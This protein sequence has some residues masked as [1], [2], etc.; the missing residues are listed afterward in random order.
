MNLYQYEF[1]SD[2][3]LYVIILILSVTKILLLHVTVKRG[4]TG[5]DAYPYV[6]NL[7]GFPLLRSIK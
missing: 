6:S 5:G 2:V 4:R 7:V 3:Q 1:I